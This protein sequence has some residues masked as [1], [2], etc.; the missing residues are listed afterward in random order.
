MKIQGKIGMA[1]WMMACLMFPIGRGHNG[2]VKGLAWD[3]VGKYLAT[4]GD[5]GEEKA[6]VIWRVRDWQMEGKTEKPFRN[7]PDETMFLRLSW[8]PD[9]QYIAGTNA[10]VKKKNS[11]ALLERP[12][13]G[14]GSGDN[15]EW[16]SSLQ[17]VGSFEPVVVGAFHP[18]LLAKQRAN[19]ALVNN[20]VCAVGGGD[21]SLTLWSCQGSTPIF[22][23]NNLFDKQIVDI[24]WGGKGYTL[25]ACSIDGTVKIIELSPG[26]IGR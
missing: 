1:M 15:G 18:K 24:T 10:F 9:G 7:A 17:F 21:R 12:K 26:E 11:C 16:K 6:V 22:V 20:M 23:L 14:A 3:P 2:M 19:G 4:Q 5:G 25:A 8:S 13:G